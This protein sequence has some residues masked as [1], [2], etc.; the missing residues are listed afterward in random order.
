MIVELL[1]MLG[2][3]GSLTGFIF[4]VKYYFKTWKAKSDDKKILLAIESS[5]DENAKYDKFYENILD[6]IDTRAIF[7]FIFISLIAVM[8]FW[9]FA[10]PNKEISNGNQGVKEDVPSTPILINSSDNSTMTTMEDITDALSF[11]GAIPWWLVPAGMIIIFWWVFRRARY[12][13]WDG[14]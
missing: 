5:E 10:S 11:N 7:T 8:L 4:F 1:V 2:F 9:V 13:S 12:S 3:L 14:I 6:K